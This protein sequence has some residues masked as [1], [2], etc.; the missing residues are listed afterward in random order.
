ML[1]TPPYASGSINVNNIT[2]LGPFYRNGTLDIE[3]SGAS[4][5]TITLTGPLFINGNTQIGMNGQQFNIN[6]N[7]QTI[8]VNS[9]TIGLPYA[10]QMGGKC[11]L[12]GSGAIIAIGDIECKPSI[13]SGPGDYLS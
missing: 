2:T 10:L 13:G 6:L 1:G 5:K 7:G 8:Y 12:Q 11:T 9:N 3:N 4:G